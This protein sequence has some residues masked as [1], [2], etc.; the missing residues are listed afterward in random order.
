MNDEATMTKRGGKQ[1]MLLGLLFAGCDRQIPFPENTSI[2]GYEV[3]G[4]ITDQVG[5]PIPN[6]TVLLDYTADVIPRDSAA[7]RRYFVQDPSVPI[8]AVVAD[9]SNQVIRILTPPQN[10]Y[11]WYEVRWD[12]A[13][14]TGSVPPSGIYYVEYLVGGIIK[15]SY[16]QLVSG[17]K[18]ATTDAGGRYTIPIQYLPLDSSSVPEFSSYDS[19]FVGNLL[20]SNTVF[21]TYLYPNHVQ[22]VVRTLDKNRVTVINIIFD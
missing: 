8:Q 20:I 10:F 3:Q 2:N 18:V 1:L 16:S 13:D 17:G 21:L 19:S 5:N 12:G 15:F 9:W 6:V 14:S 22:Q 7:T 4:T 11:G